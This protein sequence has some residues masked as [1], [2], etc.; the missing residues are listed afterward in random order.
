[1]RKKAYLTGNE[2]Y[3][4][5]DEIIVSKTDA[6][7]RITYANDVFLRVSLFRE[8]EL[9][10]KPH[11][12]IRHPKM[13]RCVFRFLW[14][15]ISTGHEVFAYVINRC[16]NGDHYWVFAHVTP[17]YDARG[18]IVGYHSN[19]RVPSLSALKTI[20]PIYAELLAEE[21]RH[22]TPREQWRA[23]LPILMDKLDRLGVTYDE[24]VF[25]LCASDQAGAPK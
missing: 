8:N 5:D 7:G 4:Q 20:K 14:D 2:R 17:T 10:G 22:Q 11:N 1:M 3:F 12:I 24:L 25:S 19:R 23:S 18:E 13:P 16:K 6:K 9:L 15:R 21:Q